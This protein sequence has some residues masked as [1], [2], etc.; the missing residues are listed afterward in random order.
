MAG[1]SGTF[2]GLND[3]FNGSV[4]SVGIPYT[5]GGTFDKPVP[6]FY[7]PDAKYS[8]GAPVDSRIHGYVGP[9]ELYLEFESNKATITGKLAS[10]IGHKFGFTGYAQI[11][12]QLPI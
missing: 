10:S 12:A 3:V 6:P 11:L 2:E 8:E 7:V 4:T 1:R 5:I 9:D